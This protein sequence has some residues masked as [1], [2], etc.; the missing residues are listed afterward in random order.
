M[1]KYY[2][3]FVFNGMLYTNVLYNSNN[4]DNVSKADE[5]SRNGKYTYR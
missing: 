5:T 2:V 4:A 3:K 1:K